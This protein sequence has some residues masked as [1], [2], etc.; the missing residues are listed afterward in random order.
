MDRVKRH[1]IT[2]LFLVMLYSLASP[3]HAA[4]VALPTQPA[5]VQQVDVIEPFGAKLFN[6]NFLKARGDGLNPNYILAPGDKVAVAVWGAVTIKDIYTIDS[7]GNIFMPE[8]G[9]L[10]L[11]GVKNAD[12]TNTVRAHIKKVYTSNFDVY[13]NLATAQPVAV[14]VTGMVNNPGRYAGLPSDSILYFLDLADGIDPKLGSYRKIEIIR[15]GKPI[16]TTDLYDFILKGKIASP[17]LQENDTILVTQR[18]AV[19]Q[20]EGNVARSALIEMESASSSGG[21]ILKV[22]PKA[23][24]AT[25]VTIIGMRNG[26][27]IKQTM[28]LMTFLDYPLRDGDT[29]TLRDD[30]RANTILINIQGEFNGPAT[31]SVKRGSRLVDV[32]NHIPVDP[33]LANTDAIHLR[34]VSVAVAQKDAISDALFRLERSSMLA[35]SGSQGEVG[36]R[37]Q[38]AELMAKFAERARLIDPLGRVVTSQ[39]GVQQNILLEPEDTLVIPTNT[40]IVRTVG[41]VMMMHAVTH[42]EGWTAEQ[43]IQ[44]A[45]GYSDRADT[46]KVIIHHPNAEVEV[47]DPQ[48]IIKPGDEIIVPPRVDSKTRQ[49]ALDLMDVIYK[50]AISA[51]VA[52]TL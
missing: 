45:G 50:I 16:N 35:L 47:T 12:L 7:Q 46:E 9:P 37:T 4:E 27:P 33:G 22:I 24:Q 29:V 31:L 40:Q 36:I 6:G 52:F 17:Q 28:P 34:R 23:A 30:G 5:V 21:E 41:E 25:E 15:A 13:T 20:L 19:V 8:V 42:R 43:Y 14:F 32:L 11:E 48:A 38:E 10:R 1:F 39:D 49:F 18:G 3:L 2:L 26:L 44:K 51:K